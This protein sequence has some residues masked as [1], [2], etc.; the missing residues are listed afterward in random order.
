MSGTRP[1]QLIAEISFRDGG[2][3]GE[4]DVP[5]VYGQEE[6]AKLRGHHFGYNESAT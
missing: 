2:R 3:Q 5:L 6:R 1:S 4:L